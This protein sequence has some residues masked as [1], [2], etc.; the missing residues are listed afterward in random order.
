[1]TEWIAPRPAGH[2]EPAG[3]PSFSVIIAAYEAA[4]TV[5]EAI[6]SALSQTLPPLEVIVCDDGS[7]D[8]IAGAVAPYA[9]DIVFLR[10]ENGGE[11]SAKNAAARAA[12]G[13]YVVVLDA[14]DLYLPGR[15][16]ALAELARARPDLDILTTDA[17]I[18]V[19][20]A[21]IRRCYTGSFRFEAYDQR[22]AILRENFVFGHVAVRRERFLAAGG[23]DEAIRWTTDWDCWLRM[24]LG[25]SR[26]GLVTEPLSRYRVQSGS[27]S[28]QRESHIAGRLQTLEKAVGRTDLSEGERAVVRSSISANQV[29]H[30]E[31][32]ARA[33][34]LEGR[35]DARRHALEV[36]LGRG[37]GLGTRVK[38][39]AAAIAPASA[40]RRLARAPRETTA[41]IRVP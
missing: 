36:S 17:L 11:A 38:A 1:M 5:G 35:P 40:R 23:Y 2:V 28:S 16:E 22:R 29:T 13:E 3:T 25:G 21:V 32:R 4:E 33:G 30:R 18:E 34:L 19:D 26:A 7:T 24:I 27:L 31:A 9:R 6:E 41:G 8:D 39:L 12:S 37:H 15:L 14:D 10:Q 20:G